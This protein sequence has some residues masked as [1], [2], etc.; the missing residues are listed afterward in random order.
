VIRF[1]NP[2]VLH[3]IDTITAEL[4]WLIPEDVDRVI[5]EIPSGRVNPR[6]H[7]GGG[8]GLSIYGMGVGVIRERMMAQVGAER[9]VTYDERWTGG[10]DKAFRKLQAAR[11]SK[12]YRAER[13]PGG[14]EADALCLLIYHFLKTYPVR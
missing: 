2:D 8:A 7:G 10:H 9:L 5:L 6:R 14:D 4:F 3:R 1:R 13:D 11:L 12:G